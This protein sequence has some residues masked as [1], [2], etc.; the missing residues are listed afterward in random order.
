MGDDV[1]FGPPFEGD[2]ATGAAVLS[3]NN[4]L[5]AAPRATMMI[6]DAGMTVT[7]R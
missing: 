4:F 1:C 7:F 5:G 6:L 3:A 2:G